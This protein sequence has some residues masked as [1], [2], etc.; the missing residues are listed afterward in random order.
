M[1]RAFASSLSGFFQ[2]VL[3]VRRPSEAARANQARQGTLSDGR[4]RTLSGAHRSY[5][6]LKIRA[7]AAEDDLNHALEG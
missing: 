1:M 7:P 6:E 5:L 2:R 4:T 3:R